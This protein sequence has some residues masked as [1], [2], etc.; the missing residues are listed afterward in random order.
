MSETSCYIK[1][2]SPRDGKVKVGEFRCKHGATDQIVMLY[3]P[4]ESGNL[5]R[6]R[7]EY[8]TLLAD[9]WERLQIEGYRSITYYEVNPSP[10]F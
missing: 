8:N 3:V 4:I 6:A 10:L 7:E 1:P 2:D 9:E 5:R